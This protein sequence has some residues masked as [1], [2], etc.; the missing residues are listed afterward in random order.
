GECMT[1]DEAYLLTEGTKYARS[2]TGMTPLDR[3][4]SIS[5]NSSL[6][7]AEYRNLAQVFGVSSAL[8]EVSIQLA[9]A[10]PGQ[11]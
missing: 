2:L 8:G 5:E 11:D 3:A 1:D 7:S 9:Q 6:V 4:K 10:A